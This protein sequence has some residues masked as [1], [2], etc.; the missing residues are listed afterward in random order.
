RLRCQ[1]LI[2]FSFENLAQAGASMGIVFGDED[3]HAC[4]SFIEDVDGGVCSCNSKRAPVSDATAFRSP[5]C[6]RARSLAIVRPIPVPVTP[7]D[8][9]LLRRWNGSQI[10]RK[11]T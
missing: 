4:G 11:S 6:L 3:L 1:P 10:D 7:S 2:A 9:L 5:P 8:N